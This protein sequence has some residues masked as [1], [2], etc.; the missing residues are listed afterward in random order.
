M[1]KNWTIIRTITGELEEIEKYDWVPYGQLLEKGICIDGN[2]QK[3]FAPEKKKTKVFCTVE[4]QKV[5]EVDAKKQTVS[6]DLILTLKW[7]DP[8]IRTNFVSNN[9][10]YEGVALRQE[11]T[12]KIW[13]PDL[14]IWNST[15]LK[16]KEEWASLK[17]SRIFSPD[18]IIENDSNHSKTIVE[19]EYEIKTTVYCNFQFSLFPMDEQNCSITAGSGSKKAIFVLNDVAQNYHSPVTYHAVG[20]EMKITFFEKDRLFGNS[21]IGFNIAMT[22]LLWPYMMKYYIPCIAIVLVSEIGFVIPLTAI[23]GRVALLVTQFLTLINLFI[24]QMVRNF[25]FDII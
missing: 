11:A 20:L 5:R 1:I 12:E 4:Y 18:M 17:E 14:Y 6:I 23:P 15:K 13:T 8:N 22:R 7:H 25:S 2:Y 3:N 21:T 9:I 10:E 19:M 24:Y 16:S